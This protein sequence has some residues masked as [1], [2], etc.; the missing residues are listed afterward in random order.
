MLLLVRSVAADE[1]AGAVAT[2][3]P[4]TDWVLADVLLV[5]R[6][7]AAVLEGLAFG[8]EGCAVACWAT[9]ARTT[10]AKSSSKSMNLIFTDAL[11]GPL[12]SASVFPPSVT[13]VAFRT[14]GPLNFISI[15][16]KSP[17]DSFKCRRPC[18]GT[19]RNQFP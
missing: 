5:R 2:V 3:L 16:F 11:R 13:P 14:I 12:S 15:T 18:P 1:S 7:A 6:L 4:D 8:W 19:V 9:W 17:R 10:H